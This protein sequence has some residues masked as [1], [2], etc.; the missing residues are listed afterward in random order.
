[1]YTFNNT[2]PAGTYEVVAKM[3]DAGVQ[4]QAMTLS[5]TAATTTEAYFMLNPG[6]GC[7]TCADLC[8]GVACTSTQV[9]AQQPLPGTCNAG[10]CMADAALG[11]A[12]SVGVNP[13]STVGRPN[14]YVIRYSS[15]NYCPG[16]DM[17]HVFTAPTTRTYSFSVSRVS[18][19][20]SMQWY[21]TTSASQVC[22]GSINYQSPWWDNVPGS[23]Y[24]VSLTAG[25]SIYLIVDGDGVTDSGAYTVNIN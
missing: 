1:V 10:V 4:S 23:T 21:M 5:V 8:S 6:S 16:P 18:G 20:T 14:N 11:S 3:P 15:T 24:N 17:A 25:Q 19:S 22:S 9:C 7:P 13:G 12:L 2:L